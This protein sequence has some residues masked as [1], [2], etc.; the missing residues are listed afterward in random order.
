MRATS[1]NHV[2][3][4]ARDLDES[5]R[6]YREVFDLEPQPS[7]NFGF[8]VRWFTLG[9]GQ[10]HLFQ[11]PDDAP[12]HHHVGLNV[13]NFE[14]VYR[15]AEARG[16]FDTTTFGHHLME[17]PN[18]VVQLYIRDPSGNLLEINWPDARSLPPAIA[19]PL[20][21]LA[22]RYPQSAENMEA[23]LFAGAGGERS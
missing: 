15:E 22:D 19:Q 9:D 1:I 3:V 5:T 2:S 17:L 20:R 21:R 6:F 14:A 12:L 18:N 16:I 10:L 13:D 8:P 23:S 11:R 4:S 7:P